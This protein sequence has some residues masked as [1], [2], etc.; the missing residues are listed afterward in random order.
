[1]HVKAQFPAECKSLH[2]TPGARLP[3][4]ANHGLFGSLSE[5]VMDFGAFFYSFH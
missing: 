4:S 3:R 1:M 2:T 5:T